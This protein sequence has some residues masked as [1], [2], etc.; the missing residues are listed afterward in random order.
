MPEVR[1]RVVESGP[2]RLFVRDV[3]EGR[4]LVVVHGGPDFDHR[5]LLPELDRLAPLCRLV[6]Y[7]QRGRGRSIL[8]EVAADVTVRS[9][10]EDLDVIRRALELGSIV[11]LGHSWGALVAL[12]YALAFPAAVSHLILISPAPASPDD[13]AGLRD[14]LRDSRSIEQRD[15]MAALAASPA[16]RAGD[17]E[18][19]A[20]YYRIHFAAA[21]RRPELVD[22]V[23][24][25]LR[26][27]FSDAGIVAARAIEEHLYEQTWRSLDW[28]LLTRLGQLRIPTLIIH[29]DAD[30]I[31]LDVARHIADAI[32]DA[33]L[34][35]LGDCGHFA[36]LEQ[37]AP[38]YRAVAGFLGPAGSD[39]V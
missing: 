17:V 30:L 13:A 4:P 23:V 22:E 37:P 21:L 10:V 7:D 20:A 6:Y 14:C 38:T 2:A 15:R 5:Y 26:R 31:P 19:D 35:V 25:R 29:G 12:E 34:E 3:G 16:F 9:E 24:A 18:A 36:Y 33:R 28:E 8:G 32:P 1:E 27:G 39:Q 11:V